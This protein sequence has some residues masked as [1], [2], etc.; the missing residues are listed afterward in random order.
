MNILIQS[1]IISRLQKGL[2]SLKRITTVDLVKTTKHACTVGNS[3]CKGSNGHYRID[4]KSG[5]SDCNWASD[6]YREYK[7]GCRSLP[8]EYC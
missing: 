7:M 1:L 6:L 2:L 3:I 4:Y 8:I 5:A